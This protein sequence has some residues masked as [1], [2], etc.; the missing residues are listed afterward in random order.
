MIALDPD[1]AQLAAHAPPRGPREVTIESIRLSSPSLFAFLTADQIDTAL[2]VTS[3]SFVRTLNRVFRQALGDP[4]GRGTSCAHSYPAALCAAT[5]DPTWVMH[6]WDTRTPL[7]DRWV[8]TAEALVTALSRANF[9][10]RHAARAAGRPT[11]S[12][13]VD[14]AGLA[15][16]ASGK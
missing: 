3:L 16:S 7:G 8:H 15:S 11:A 14:R 4:P 1:V 12:R 5:D 6:D 10:C 13:D 9:A 2:S